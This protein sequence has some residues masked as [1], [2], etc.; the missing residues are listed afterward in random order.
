MVMQNI[1][2]TI[3][4]LLIIHILI[5]TSVN[6]KMY[7]VGE[8]IT[9]N[10]LEMNKNFILDLSEGIWTVINREEYKWGY[11]D[12]TVWGVAKIENKEIV[13]FYEVIWGDMG[14][15]LQSQI[16]PLI[17]S[18]QFKDPYDGCYERPEYYLVRV[19]KKGRTHN[20]M[21][22]RHWDVVKQI[23]SPDDPKSKWTTVQYRKFLRE[24]GVKFPKMALGSYH[25]YF[26]RHNK[27]NWYQVAYVIHPKLI[28]GPKSKFFTEDTS[29]Y[30][31]YNIEKNPN[32][33]KAMEKFISIASN[34]HK[35]FEF[36]QKAQKHHLL[37]LSKYL[38]EDVK[39]K[40]MNK[41]IVRQLKE[42]NDLYKSGAL[43]GYEF[44]KAKKKLLN[45]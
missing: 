37:D 2:K 29:E 9:N 12:F 28:D 42:L 24:S 18:A 39:V 16:D 22:I 6:A 36:M 14:M 19:F 33:K 38:T 25:S 13:E 43:S 41:D 27:N 20:C 4:F 44:E 30:H 32:H 23:H 15:R 40:S 1:I 34:F 5:C 35:K 17:Y 8:Q 26:S 7:K 11:F 31:K 10:Q 45:N 21:V 3:K